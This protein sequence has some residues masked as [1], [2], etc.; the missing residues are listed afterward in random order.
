MHS[1]RL[2]DECV[3]CTVQSHTSPFSQGQPPDGCFG[4]PV[5]DGTTRLLPRTVTAEWVVSGPGAVAAGL[6][7][8][9]AGTDG[10]TLVNC[11]NK[12]EA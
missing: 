3:E 7:T 2:T 9:F 5:K 1:K 4:T 11:W 10:R 6:N 8:W 12:D